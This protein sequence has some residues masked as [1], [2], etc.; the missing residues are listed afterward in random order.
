MLIVGRFSESEKRF[1]LALK[2]W[3]EFNSQR[4]TNTWEL[5][6]IGFGKDENIYKEYARKNKLNNV[7]FIGKQD[8]L[9]YYKKASI[10]LMTSAF[11]GFGLTLTE[12][13]RIFSSE[14]SLLR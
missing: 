11:E 7:K 3:K 8:P 10:F 4:I 5:I 6:I 9:E 1:L 14:W 13:K 2:A 12:K